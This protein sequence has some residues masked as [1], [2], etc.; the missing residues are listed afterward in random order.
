MIRTFAI[1]VTA[2]LLSAGLVGCKSQTQE[3][4][5]SN[6]RKQWTDVNAD[7]A[8]TTEAAKK[9][10]TNEGLKEVMGDSTAQDGKVTG[11]LA[12]G[13]KVDAAIAKNGSGSTVTVTVG[14]LG[15]PTMGAELAKKI[16]LAAEGM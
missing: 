11:K 4:V 14:T 3:G 1:A 10:F 6:L 16:K 15:S 12:D 8:K 5:T 13:T 9:V 2:A 7:T